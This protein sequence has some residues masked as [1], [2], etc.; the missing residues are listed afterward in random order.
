MGG[1]E[2]LKSK[3]KRLT[4]KILSLLN[5]YDLINT[6]LRWTN[7]KSDSDDGTDV[8]VRPNV[9]SRAVHGRVETLPV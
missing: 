6:Y 3:S 5:F 8:L 4:D 1:R 2:E 9:C 7:R